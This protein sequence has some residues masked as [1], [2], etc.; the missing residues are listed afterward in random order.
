MVPEDDEDVEE[1]E[2]PERAE[3]RSSPLGGGEDPAF[4]R[5][6]NGPIKDAVSAI[7]AGLG[8]KPDWSQ[9]TDDGF[10]PPPPEERI[11]EWAIFLPHQHRRP[12]GPPRLPS[13][14]WRIGWPPG[15]SDEPAPPPGEPATRPPDPDRSP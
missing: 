13:R 10:P 7:C 14:A 3:T 4:Y 15:P 12:A 9:W 1:P 5:L 2:R 11:T 8:L 6:L